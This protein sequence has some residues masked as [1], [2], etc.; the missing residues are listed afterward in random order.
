[1]HEVS[2][3][4]DQR[5]CWHNAADVELKE[6]DRFPSHRHLKHA[7][8]FVLRHRFRHQHAP[9]DH[10]ADPG[11]PGFQLQ[12]RSFF[13]CCP[14]IRHATRLQE[15][16]H[17][18]SSLTPEILVAPNKVELA[19]RFIRA[20]AVGN[21]REL[22]QTVKEEQEIAEVCN[23]LIRNSIICWNYLYLTRRL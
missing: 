10:R 18:A 4:F 17:N 22:S 20:V 14:G 19:N 9:P 6:V 15:A 3:A 5:I 11:Q 1:M 12:S 23:R 7:V 13:R 8:K 16:L 21:P 2:T